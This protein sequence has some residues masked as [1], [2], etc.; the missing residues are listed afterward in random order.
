MLEMAQMES[1]SPISRGP[2]PRQ[3]TVLPFEPPLPKRFETIQNVSKRLTAVMR[4]A[5]CFRFGDASLRHTR[6]L[7]SVALKSS[8]LAKSSRIGRARLVSLSRTVHKR[9]SCECEWDSR[10]GAARRWLTKYNPRSV[11]WLL[12]VV[13]RKKC[14]I[15]IL[16]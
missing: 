12:L 14:R 13:S 9:A 5:L 15:V 8:P 10:S 4:L 7:R 1:T 11:G 16:V 2:N 3:R 6:H